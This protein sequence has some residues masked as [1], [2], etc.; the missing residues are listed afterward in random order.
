M[1]RK[2]KILIALIFLPVSV[3]ANA[4][5][6]MVWF[7]FLHLLYVN[8]AIGVVESLII[9]R[10]KLENKMWLI[11][12]ANYVSMIVGLVLIAPFFSTLAGNNDFWRME[13]EYS[14]RG[15]F[16]GMFV[17]YIATLLIEFPFVYLSVK[18]KIMRK[19]V[20]LPFIMANTITYTAMTLIYFLLNIPGS[21]W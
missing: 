9:K 7:G 20:I 16:V 1:N 11:I 6:F 10:Y 12:I 2:I 17:A 13:H 14:L 19:K 15:F 4:G 21:Y 18:E 5:S 3:F 8:A